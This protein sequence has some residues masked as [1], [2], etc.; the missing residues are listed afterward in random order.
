MGT[1]EDRGD[2]VVLALGDG[3]LS[4]GAVRPEGKRTMA[5]DAWMRGRR[6]ETARLTTG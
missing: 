6:G 4:L 3:W 2:R 1:I 5:A